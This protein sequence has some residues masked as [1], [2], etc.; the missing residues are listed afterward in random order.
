MA[1]TDAE[2]E[3]EA[4]AEADDDDDA[5][6]ETDAD[7]RLFSAE[8]SSVILMQLGLEWRRKQAPPHPSP[9]PPASKNWINNFL[10]V[11]VTIGFNG[12]H[13]VAVAAVANAAPTP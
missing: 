11:V 12:P 7:F 5:D 13:C 3:A 1:V 4:E 2:A 9:H 8:L 10:L 6:A